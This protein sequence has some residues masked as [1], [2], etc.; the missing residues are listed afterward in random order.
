[1][2]ALCVMQSGL[3]AS[4]LNGQGHQGNFPMRKLQS[5]L[6]HL[7]SI[8]PVDWNMLSLWLYWK[9]ALLIFFYLLLIDRSVAGKLP[10]L[11]LSPG[12]GRG[13]GQIKFSKTQNSQRAKLN[14]NLARDR[15]QLSDYPSGEGTEQY[16][17]CWASPEE[18]AGSPGRVSTV[19][20]DGSRLFEGMLWSSAE[21]KWSAG[22]A[23][24]KIVFS[25]S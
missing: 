8:R 13:R 18:R 1:M 6:M 10:L 21:S 3:Y 4:F 23:E 22:V 9:C 15:C 16:T 11:P 2:S 17:R 19:D 14:S 12:R 25:V 24:Y 5:P 7:W 20:V